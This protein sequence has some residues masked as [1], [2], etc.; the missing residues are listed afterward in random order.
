MINI[1]AVPK[2][3]I[4]NRK[5]ESYRQIIKFL[6]ETF[7]ELGLSIHKIHRSDTGLIAFATPV[8]DSSLCPLCRTVCRHVHKYYTRTLESLEI[9]G[10][11]VIVKVRVRYYYCDCP[12]CAR[13]TFSEPLV[14]ADR[15]AR[16]SRQAEHRILE[17][18]LNLSS[19]KASILLAAQN[20]HASISKCTRQAKSLGKSNPC[21]NSTHIGIDDFAFKRGHVYMCMASDHDSGKPVAVFN[22]RYGEELDEWLRKNPQIELVTRDGSHDYA[23][24]IRR[25]LP[26]ATQVSDK[27]HLVKNLLEGVVASFQKELYQ[28]NEKR[29]YPFPSIEE[30][31]NY[32]L[33]DIYGMGEK[34]HRERVSN[35]L[36]VK[37]MIAKGYAPREIV[38]NIGKSPTYIRNLIHGKSLSVHLDT[39]QRKALKYASQVANIVSGGSL[40][41]STIV[42]KMEGSLDSYLISRMM[43]TLTRVYTEKRKLVREHNKELKTSKA[44]KKVP[45][46]SIRHLVLKGET[47]D[48]KLME[49]IKSEPRVMEA[50][51]LCIS[52]RKMLKEGTTDTS[53]G[54]WIR[55]AKISVNSHLVRFAYNMEEDKEAVQAAIDTQYS[56]ARLE[57]AVN[58]VKCIKRTMYNRAG[59]SLLRAKIIY[60]L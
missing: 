20:I 24:A 30:A 33:R 58:R 5:N 7:H 44:K 12:A 31:Y 32:I 10:Q 36:Q 43:R 46:R 21:C 54:E 49:I 18:S 35:F 26:E 37:E 13:C 17:T 57:G 52:F 2:D 15:Y 4:R 60:G 8:S 56:N 51:G 38:E 53:M 25:N 22:C 27:F 40:S 41:I 39:L 16:K 9:F 47:N 48:E 29:S 19:G 1:P 11:S 34:K 28:T 45:V 14:M 23:R 55:M 6:D 42:K 3:T 50:V 59:I